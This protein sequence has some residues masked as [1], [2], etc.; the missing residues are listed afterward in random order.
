MP[1]SLVM[2]LCYDSTRAHDGEYENYHDNNYY[3]HASP[4]V[5]KGF[6]PSLDRL[7]TYYLCQ[8]G[9]R[10]SVQISSEYPGFCFNPRSI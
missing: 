6:E 10:D 3:N 9:L 7:S 2:M 5:T 8:V 1:R 4:I